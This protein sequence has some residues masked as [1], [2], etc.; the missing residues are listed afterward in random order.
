MRFLYSGFLALITTACASAAP[1]DAPRDRSA[2][3]AAF[4]AGF[5]QVD[6]SLSEAERAEALARFAAL[7]E[8][9]GAIS[10]PEFELAIAEIVALS[11]NGHT[12]VLPARWATAFPTLGVRF[13]IAA[14]G[15]FVADALDGYEE[16]VGA[17]VATIDGHDLDA[18]RAAW[19]RYFPGPEGYRDNAMY[20]FLEAPAMLHAA[21]L[22]AREDAVELTLADGRTESVGV[23]DGW[24]A[25]TGVWAFLPSSREI[26]LAK[27]GRI[28]GD[29]FYLQDPDA[30]FRV[31]ELPDA[32]AAYVQFRANVYFD[33]EG[34]MRAETTAAIDRLRALAPKAVIVDQR[35]NLGGDLNTTHDLMQAI[36]EI[37]GPDGRV[38]A[39]I[40]GRTFSAGIASTAYLKQAGGDRVT[41][42]GSPAGDALEFWAEGGPFAL[43]D[44]GALVAI[45]TERHNYMTGCPEDDCHISIREHPIAIDDLEPDVLVRPTYEDIAAGR[46]PLMAAALALIAADGG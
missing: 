44:T 30:Y 35:L 13:L 6:Q 25:P 43:P 4:E 16:L 1:V 36:P 28:A 7:Q 10:D 2:D 14:D 42:V 31:V 19:D 34:D 33:D 40:S 37:V 9:A 32:D 38:V 24:P 3:L 27:A 17:P 18:L 21:G 26:Q 45:A 8:T 46:D 12:M 5:L 15:L 11:D 41:L 39:L 23:A 22:A 20:F 29:P